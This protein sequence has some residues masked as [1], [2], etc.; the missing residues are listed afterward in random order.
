MSRH[1]AD[2]CLPVRVASTLQV[3]VRAH[4]ECHKTIAMLDCINRE[5]VVDKWT[6]KVLSAD[7]TLAIKAYLR[8]HNTWPAAL[9]QDQHTAEDGLVRKLN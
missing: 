6:C 5:L 3:H 4:T 8:S 9:S 1:T 2:D 7:L